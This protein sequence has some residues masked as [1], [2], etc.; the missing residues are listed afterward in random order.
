MEGS[1]VALWISSGVSVVGVIYTIVRNGSRGK[2]Q[3]EKLKSE[4]K[5]EIKNIQESISDGT[6]GLKAI[7]KAVDDQALNCMKISTKLQEEVKK[8]SEDIDDI[9]E[10]VPKR[11]EF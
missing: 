11:R 10:K 1:I 6:T 3:D 7:K 2:I 8:N 9:V 4:L 5:L